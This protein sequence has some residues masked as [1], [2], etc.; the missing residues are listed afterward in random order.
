MARIIKNE[1][2]VQGPSFDDLF[3]IPESKEQKDKRRNDL[4][5]D[6]Q[7]VD[8]KDLSDK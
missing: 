6:D 8:G 7:E 2:L 5:S 4:H 3:Y 1:D